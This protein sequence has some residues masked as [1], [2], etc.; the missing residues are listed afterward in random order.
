MYFQRRARKNTGCKDNFKHRETCTKNKSVKRKF[1][2]RKVLVFFAII[3]G[4]QIIV[5]YGHFQNVMM[6]LITYLH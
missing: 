3:N 4:K 1:L 5:I 6:L 2:A